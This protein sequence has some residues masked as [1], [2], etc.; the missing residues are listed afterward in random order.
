[1]CLAASQSGPQFG[2]DPVLMAQRAL[3]S[4]SR[5]IT[6]NQWTPPETAVSHCGDQMPFRNC[7][8]VS[9]DNSNGDGPL[10]VSERD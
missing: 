10:V 9:G 8:A 4:V 7:R 2:L 5:E 1:M 6:R 3:G